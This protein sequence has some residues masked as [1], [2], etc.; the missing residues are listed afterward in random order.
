MARE[1]KTGL[2]GRLAKRYF[3][4]ALSAMALGLFS[5]LIIGLIIEQFSKI[6]GL[7]CLKEYALAAQN[8]YVT[9]GA[10]GAAVAYGLKAKPLAV[11]SSIA[12]GAFA[13]QTEGRLGHMLL[14]L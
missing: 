11:F 2:I 6:P 3:I 5:S 13:Y 10:I 7:G 1:K 8:G 14:C 12:F 4:D 9:G